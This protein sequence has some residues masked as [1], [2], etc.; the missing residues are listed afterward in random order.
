[1]KSLKHL[2]VALVASLAVTTGAWAQSC[3]NLDVNLLASDWNIVTSAAVCQH[4]KVAS[5]G[6]KAAVF[7]TIG[8]YGPDCTV[9]FQ[10]PAGAF[11]YVEFQ[12][13]FCVTEGGTI[14][15]TP[16][17]FQKPVYISQEGSFNPPTDGVVTV[18]AFSPTAAMQ[19]KPPAPKKNPK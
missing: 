14:T 17:Q 7:T 13:N 5:V 4:G 18:L 9:L 6:P 16:L 2:G 3:N 12:Q 15:V 10:G 11:A 1:M 8:T 19:V